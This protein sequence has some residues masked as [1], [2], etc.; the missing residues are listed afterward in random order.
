M[1]GNQSILR[2]NQLQIENKELRLRLEEAEEAL[3][4]IRNGEV[5]AIIVTGKQGEQVFS[6][7]SAETPYRII[8]E[9]MNDGAVSLSGN[10]IINYCNPRFA[11]LINTASAKIYG[12]EFVQFVVPKDRLRFQSMLK[13][14]LQKNYQDTI[15]CQCGPGIVKQFLISISPIPNP[16]ISD[17]ILVVTDI[18]KLKEIEKKLKIALDTLEQKVSDRTSELQKL[19]SDKDRFF[20]IIAHDLIT[21]FNGFL[22]LT[23]IMANSLYSLSLIE[24]QEMAVAMENSAKNLLRLLE[25]LLK[26]SQIE[27]GLISFKPQ[28]HNLS[29]IATESISTILHRS[30]SKGVTIEINI[31][32][33]LSVFADSNMLQTVI[34]NLVSNAVKFTNKGGKVNISAKSIPENQI[35]LSVKDNGIGMSRAIINEIFHLSGKAKRKG[36]EGEISTG[37]GLIICQDFIKKHHGK[38]GIKS[39]VGKG[40]NFYFNLPATNGSTINS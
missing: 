39:T 32:H 25:N 15:S 31:S 26:W 23:N 3:N 12:T 20:T 19:I 34:R 7:T 18:T 4:A 22:G 38:L 16:E 40:S 29:L 11:E 10:G 36:T 13:T 35:E 24:I 37:L 28:V 21:P 30:E 2:E 33:Q 8:I 14:G 17:Q 6:L 1:T 9:Q 5:D 27:Q